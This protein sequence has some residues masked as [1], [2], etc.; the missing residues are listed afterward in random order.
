MEKYLI[1]KKNKLKALS[2]LLIYSIILILIISY[3][4][5][6][7]YI[8]DKNTLY[9]ISALLIGFY[10]TVIFFPIISLYNNYLKYNKETVL[11]INKEFIVINKRKID[12]S[13]IKKV[14]IYAN[15]TYLKGQGS[16]F[17]HQE[18][19]YYMKI[20]LQDDSKFIITSLLGHNIYNVFRK[21]YPNL[22]F[23]ENKQFIPF[24][25]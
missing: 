18:V 10:F 7:L 23:I 11:I 1:S 20:Q 12:I 17:P 22:K 21:E 6:E 8:D 2:E 5:S 16:K 25:K 13:E 14:N 4:T 9:F 15:A 19:F 3:L 24:V